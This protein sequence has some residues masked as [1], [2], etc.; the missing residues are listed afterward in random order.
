MS[1][2]WRCQMGRKHGRNYRTP[3]GSSVRCDFS[4]RPG[5][6]VLTAA[7][8]TRMVWRSESDL[9]SVC[10]TSGRDLTKHGLSTPPPAPSSACIRFLFIQQNNSFGLAQDSEEARQADKG[11]AYRQ[12]LPQHTGKGEVLVDAAAVQQR[13]SHGT[14]RKP[15]QVR[16]FFRKIT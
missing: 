10:T 14:C 16:F 12:E 3:Q 2:P 6:R 1:F 13:R 7:A 5:L 4:S 8:H 11:Q 9:L 15:S